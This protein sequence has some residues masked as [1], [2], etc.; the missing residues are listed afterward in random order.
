MHSSCVSPYQYSEPIYCEMADNITAQTA[1]ILTKR[2][3]LDVIGT[4]GGC[5][6]HV[7]MLALSFLIYRPLT[8]ESAR[9]IIVDCVEEFLFQINSNEEI[10]PY[11]KNYPFTP[12]EL[13]ISIFSHTEKNEAVYDPYI[14][15]VS[16][17]TRHDSTQTMLW[18]RTKAPDQPFGYKTEIE[19]DY[20]E[21]LR[22]VKG[23]KPSETS[24]S[25]TLFP[26]K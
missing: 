1:K 8:V 10:R 11:L 17:S 14:S 6:D 12:K 21:A 7:N 24:P 16:N 2:H 18:F 15:V 9:E 25:A 3:Q 4:G 5:M 23:E 26:S 19:E 13:K 20:Q 22:I